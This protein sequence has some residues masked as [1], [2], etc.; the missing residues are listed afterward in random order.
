[1][2]VEFGWSKVGWRWDICGY[3]PSW[4]AG[5]VVESVAVLDVS[6]EDDVMEEVIVL[7][8]ARLGPEPHERRPGHVQNQ[9]APL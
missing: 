3:V 9:A 8:E 5:S 2:L 4:G 1:M 7:F 6:D